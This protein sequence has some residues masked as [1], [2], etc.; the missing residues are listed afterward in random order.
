M[1]DPPPSIVGSLASPHLALKLRQ[2]VNTRR[3]CDDDAAYGLL[4][5]G[6]SDADA[7]FFFDDLGLEIDF[8]H[9]CIF[10]AAAV[11]AHHQECEP[12]FVNVGLYVQRRLVCNVL[13]SVER[14]GSH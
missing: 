11:V 12:T 9:R 2:G 1:R 13:K 4:A 14:A 6:L 7:K 10:Y 5:A 8:Q 3:H